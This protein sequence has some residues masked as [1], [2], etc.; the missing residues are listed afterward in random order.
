MLPG[1]IVLHWNGAELPAELAS[2]PPGRYVVAPVQSATA[3]SEDEEAGLLHALGSLNGGEGVDDAE[4]D[5]RVAFAL[6]R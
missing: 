3:L 6:S 5:A 2:L 1:M 4:I